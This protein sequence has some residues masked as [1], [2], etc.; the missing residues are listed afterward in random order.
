[1]SLISVFMYKGRDTEDADR[2]KEDIEE[3][4]QI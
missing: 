1:M 4:G 2:G 3:T